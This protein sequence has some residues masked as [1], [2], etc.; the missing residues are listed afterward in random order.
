MAGIDG[1]D[2]LFEDPRHPSGRP[3]SRAP[4]LIVRHR[5][6]PV[7]TLDLFRDRWVLF[8]GSTGSDWAEW[9]DDRWKGWWGTNPPYHVP[10]FVLTHQPRQ[11]VE[12]EG[13][14]VFQFVTEGIEAALNRARASAQ[15]K[16]VRIGGG[17]AT[18][19]QYLRARL[20]DEMHLAISPVLLG[21]GEPLFAGINLIALGYQ[22]KERVFTAAAMHLVVGTIVVTI[23]DHG[24]P[25]TPTSIR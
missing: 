21:S 5:D 13:G 2:D 24:T 11:P 19:R 25:M 18:I 8:S 9:P 20:V 23:D 22:V 1:D 7:S 17:A 10:V 3:G 16:D 6:A 15:G 4:H 12:L 14:T